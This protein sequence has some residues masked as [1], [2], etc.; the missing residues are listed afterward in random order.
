MTETPRSVTAE[1]TSRC[2][3]YWRKRLMAPAAPSGRSPQLAG[4]AWIAANFSFG[5]E[6]TSA[7]FAE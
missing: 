6:P 7:T 2:A 3:R 1:A 4:R 5:R